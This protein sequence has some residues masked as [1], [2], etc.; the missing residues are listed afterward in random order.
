ML[1]LCH[2]LEESMLWDY[3]ETHT[4]GEASSSI[5]FPQQFS[6]RLMCTVKG[7]ACAF[8]CIYLKQGDEMLYVYSIAVVRKFYV[9]NLSQI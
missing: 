1:V 8:V 7:S 3:I 9:H 6:F 4:G 2:L 5:R